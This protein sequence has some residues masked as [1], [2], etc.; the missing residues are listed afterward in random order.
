M[1]LRKSFE[2]AE[3]EGC[4]VSTR[5]TTPKSKEGEKLVKMSSDEY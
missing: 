1:D 2:N 5:H 3:E 4:Y